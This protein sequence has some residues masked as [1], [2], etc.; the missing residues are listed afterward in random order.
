M[1]FGRVPFYMKTSKIV[2]TP[3]AHFTKGPLTFQEQANRLISRGLI[4]SHPEELVSFLQTVNYYRF[5]GYCLAFELERH[6][7]LPNTTFE[8]I[9]QIYI[10]DKQLRVAIQRALCSVEIKLRTAMAYYLAHTYNPFAHEKRDSFWFATEKDFQ[11][12]L[13]RIHKETERSNEFFIE[14]YRTKYIEY[15]K[16]PIWML[17]EILPFGS[18]SY[19]FD[20]ILPKK[21]KAA[22]ASIF[23]QQARKFASVI[24]SFSYIR[25]ICA[26]H[27][28]LWDRNLHITPLKHPD[29]L[30]YKLMAVIFNL[31]TILL[32]PDFPQEETLQWKRDIENLID[33]HPFVPN[34]YAK[35]GLGTLRENWKSCSSWRQ[36]SESLYKK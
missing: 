22:I 5:S 9:K 6:H 27:A 14:A 16:L 1:H 17:V 35:I 10:F 18:L 19:M 32:L 31:Y 23:R 33:N 2:P 24:H 20:R 21:D 7:F 4:C 29:V 36:T 34:F 30:S 3:S 8:Q 11:E 15:P 25:N 26:H 28:R 12:W 13:E